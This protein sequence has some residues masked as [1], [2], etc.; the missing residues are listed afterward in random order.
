MGIRDIA[1]CFPHQK[2]PRDQLKKKKRLDLARE[3]AQQV[4][5]LAI[6]PDELS[7]T[8]GPTQQKQGPNPTSCPLTAAHTL[9]HT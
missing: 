9:I 1:K 8:P 7:S 6:N 4:T 2:N 3:A 5:A